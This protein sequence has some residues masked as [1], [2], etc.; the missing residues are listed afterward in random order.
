MAALRA[1]WWPRIATELGLWP[2]H[3]SW[4]AC[5]RVGSERDRVL[6]A[7]GEGKNENSRWDVASFATQLH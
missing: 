6:L 1:H 5:G 3:S 2:P 4:A 7:F